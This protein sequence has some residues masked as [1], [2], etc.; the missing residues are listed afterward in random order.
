MANRLIAATFVHTLPGQKKYFTEADWKINLLETIKTGLWSNGKR[1][2]DESRFTLLQS[3]G[4]IR[5]RK[6]VDEVMHTSCL[7][8]TIQCYDLGLV[9]LV[10]SRYSNV[11]C[12]K[13]EVG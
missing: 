13:I 2:N 10:R 7:V 4:H 11:V 5:V 3:D 12:P 1:S 8:P 9:Q 6:E